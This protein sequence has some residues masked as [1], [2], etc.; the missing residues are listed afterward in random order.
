M[1]IALLADRSQAI[2]RS[3]GVLKEE[4]GNPHRSYSFIKIIVAVFFVILLL[5]DVGE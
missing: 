1:K 4:T 3:Y 2:S 5:A